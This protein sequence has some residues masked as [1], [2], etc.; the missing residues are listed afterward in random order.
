MTFVQSGEGAHSRV[1]RAEAVKRG[2]GGALPRL[3][4]FRLVALA[5]GAK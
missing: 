2:W 5:R 1:S 3:Q 4:A